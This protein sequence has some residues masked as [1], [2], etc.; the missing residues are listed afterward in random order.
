MS[1]RDVL[2]MDGFGGRAQAISNLLRNVEKSDQPVLKVFSSMPIGKQMLRHAQSLVDE[3]KHREALLDRLDQVASGSGLVGDDSG[4]SGPLAMDDVIK[5]HINV[6]G[7]ARTCPKQ[8]A[9]VRVLLG[10]VTAVIQE[11]GTTV[12]IVLAN[13]LD[14]KLD[15]LAFE[16]GKLYGCFQTGL[17]SMKVIRGI[18]LWGLRAKPC[19]ELEA[20]AAIG[21]VIDC[22]HPAVGRFGR[23]Q[24]VDQRCRCG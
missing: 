11:Y 6:F 15:G 24:R 12:G 13:I 14:G 18:T 10:R 1:V 8:D 21:A 16:G 9:V 5:E 17:S 2:N 7:G 3:W 23:S 4:C 22:P 20:M 19:S